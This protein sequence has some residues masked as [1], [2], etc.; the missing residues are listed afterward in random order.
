[1]ILPAGIAAQIAAE[2]GSVPF[3]RFMELALTHPSD[4]YYSGEDIFLGARGHFSTAP[5]LSPEFSET[6][7]R[8]VEE[9]I[10]SMAG[11]ESV[12]LV[13]LGGGEG[14]LARAILAR[15]AEEQPDLKPRVN[16][17]IVELGQGTRARQ[18]RALA[19]FCADGW[20]VEWASTLVG[21]LAGTE[22]EPTM[23]VG[24]EFFDALPV[25]LV[26]VRE[27][28]AREAWVEAGPSVG[29][30]GG[31]VIRETWADLSP[32]AAAELRMLFGTEETADLRCVSRDG[33]IELRPA[34]GGL[35]RHLAGKGGPS[36]LLT[37]DY[38]DW[39]GEGPYGDTSE[40][41]AGA[42][43]SLTRYRRTLR[44]YFRHQTVCDL[45]ARVGAQD[46][47]AD[48][49]FRALDAHGRVAGFES[50]LYTSVAAM[51]LGDKGAER[52]TE[53]EQRAERS[54]E[55]DRRA[56]AL[57]VLLDPQEVGGAFKVMLQV[58]A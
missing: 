12:R 26:D 1:M 30:A 19:R 31:E 27:D 29:E 3:A 23:V 4:G 52:L 46:L 8:L 49:D 35:L 50:V 44:G 9:L 22:G 47:T 57:R 58:S 13:E 14:Q 42:G 34:V 43:G 40:A 28:R 20:R 2:G 10:V 7:A 33:M 54:L 15:L 38:G 39:F 36:C 24:N 41:L 56:S 25:H 5:V 11:G 17:T 51:L 53:L 6:L 18:R 55:V 45:H 32:E 16:Y 48:V 21:A 37:V